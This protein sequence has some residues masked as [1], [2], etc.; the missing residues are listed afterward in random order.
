MPPTTAGLVGRPLLLCPASTPL[1]RPETS[2]RGAKPTFVPSAGGSKPPPGR[3]FALSFFL[4]FCGA[5]LE[6]F[7]HPQVSANLITISHRLGLSGFALIR[8]VF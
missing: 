6:I 5:Q 3:L 1:G 8:T 4:E 7:Y 2:Y